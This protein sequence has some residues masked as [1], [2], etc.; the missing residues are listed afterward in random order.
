ML[1]KVPVLGRPTYFDYS[2]ARAYCAC[3][4]CGWGCLDI[5]LSSKQPTNQSVLLEFDPINP[6]Y[7]GNPQKGCRQKVQTQKVQTQMMPHNVASDLDLHYLQFVQPFLMKI[8]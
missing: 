5:F 1:G 8:S 6:F 2:R 7:S 4:R 3:S